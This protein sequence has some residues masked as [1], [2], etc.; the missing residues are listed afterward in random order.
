M[1]LATSLFRAVRR[2]VDRTIQRRKEKGQRT[3][4]VR[5]RAELTPKELAEIVLASALSERV[6][7]GDAERL[8]SRIARLAD[9]DRYMLAL[10]AEGRTRKEVAYALWRDEYTVKED[11]KRIFKVLA[12]DEPTDP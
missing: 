1:R 8:A 5:R 2:P 7:T 11:M 6:E 4:E 9:R 3:E 10:L 12:E